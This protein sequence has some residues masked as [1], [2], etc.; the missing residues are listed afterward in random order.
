MTAGAGGNFPLSAKIELPAAFQEV[1]GEYRKAISG[2]KKELREVEKEAEEILKTRG[3]VDSAVQRR[4]DALRGIQKGLQDKLDEQTNARQSELVERQESGRVQ[5]ARHMVTRVGL[6]SDKIEAIPETIKGALGAPEQI[7]TLL[8]R[9]GFKRAGAAV[10]GLAAEGGPLGMVAGAMMNPYFQAA[11]IAAGI[12]ERLLSMRTESQKAMAAASSAAAIDFTRL[13]GGN[14]SGKVLDFGNAARAERIMTEQ[15]EARKTGIDTLPKGAAELIANL[16]GFNT[17]DQI[18]EGEKHRTHRT[19]MEEA[20]QR[21]GIDFVNDHLQEENIRRRAERL[22]Q[23]ETVSTEY[24]TKQ[25]KMLLLEPGGWTKLKQ[26]EEQA[27]KNA[28]IKAE[29]EILGTLQPWQESQVA[30]WNTGAE[31]AL[32]RV[33]ENEKRR[34]LRNVEQDRVMRFNS[35]SLT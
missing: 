21:F 2:I 17:S 14:I 22:Y 1:I 30:K 35:W 5:L 23:Q 9:A 12:T 16:F 18:Q 27:R 8:Q 24:R 34:W 33:Y 6:R 29:E 10:S 3:V 32:N 28:R 26:M 7:G 19:K 13:T 11:V 31:G 15:A 20:R 25:A 4:I